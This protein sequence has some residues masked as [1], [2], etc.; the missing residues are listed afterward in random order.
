VGRDSAVELTKTEEKDVQDHVAQRT[1]VIFEIIRRQGKEE[2]SRPATS[3]FW[4]G[5][6]AGFSIGFSVLVPAYLK[7][8]LVGVPGAAVLEKI[9]YSTGFLFVIL[10]HQQLFTENTITAVIPLLARYSRDNVKKFATL[11][12][13]VL[14]ANVIGT[15]LFAAF[16]LYSGAVTADVQKAV[17]EMSMIPYQITATAVMTRG[18]IS[19]LLIASLVWMLANIEGSK[20][21]LIMIVTSIMAFGDLSHV[22]AG[23]VDAAYVGLEG[24]VPFVTGFTHF[25]VPTLIGN[26]LGGSGL[27]ALMAYAQIREERRQ[28]L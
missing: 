5:I 17:H 2:L 14:T 20:V 21:G 7:V 25:F 13:V 18:V 16:I 4:S 11:W 27:F 23:S 24:A 19:G 10:G 9:G 15:A 1:P 3:L 28:L 12:S 26:I 22:V 8:L 6:A